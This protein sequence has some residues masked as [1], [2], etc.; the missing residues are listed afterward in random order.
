MKDSMGKSD[1]LLEAKVAIVIVNWN[2]KENTFECL[3]SVRSI[4]YPCVEVIVVDNGSTDNS[5]D[6]IRERFPEVVLLR[7]EKNL[8]TAGGRN[9]G[10]RYALK[11]GADFVFF[12]DNDAIVDSQV[13]V[14]FLKAGDVIK[15]NGI[16]GP[17]IYYFSEP[18][19][20]WY[21][22]TQWKNPGFIHLGMGDTEDGQRFNSIEETAYVCGCAMFVDR[23]V[24]EKIG[25]FD[26]RFFAY[27][28]ETDFCYRAKA[29][30]FPSFFVPSAKVWH[31]VSASSGGEGSP[32][33][34]YFMNR[35]ILLW[36]ERHLPLTDKSKL[37]KS[38][39]QKLVRTILPPGIRSVTSEKPMQSR[40]TVALLRKYTEA[41]RRKYKD[42]KR[43]AT[44]I[45]FR[46]YLLRRFGNCPESVRSL[47]K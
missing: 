30:G 20:I 1:N 41:C 42:P 28:E 4:D 35:N 26:E 10:A 21:A 37:Y 46:D 33:F 39:L 36:A 2:G 8:G 16:F 11:S 32:F 34:Y 45:G 15:R 22:G 13:I 14:N 27:F 40:L 31:K 12:L 47:G 25:I 18:R 38:M 44:L 9:I 5:A 24:L 19:K 7:A 29:S 3:E 17:K 23:A 6:A 43:K